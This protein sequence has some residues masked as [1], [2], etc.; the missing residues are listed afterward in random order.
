M[1]ICIYAYYI[2]VE[3][4]REM[5]VYIHIYIYIYIY[6]PR[7]SWSEAVEGSP[8]EKKTCGTTFSRISHTVVSIHLAEA[9]KL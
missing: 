2:Y 6:G 4:E 1:H 3:R 5:Y 9:G 8:G 7:A